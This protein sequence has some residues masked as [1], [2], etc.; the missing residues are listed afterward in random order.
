M[1]KSGPH[2]PFD[3]HA[4]VVRLPSPETL[5]LSRDQHVAQVRSRMDRVVA[6]FCMALRANEY[7]QDDK[8]ITNLLSNTLKTLMN[9]QDAETRPNIFGI[10]QH[11]K[12][13]SEWKDMCAKALEELPIR[14]GPAPVE[15]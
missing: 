2:I 15:L 11:V 8:Y 4:N 9:H 14:K 5:R 12:E 13:N 6:D 3:A 1:T 7:D 10:M